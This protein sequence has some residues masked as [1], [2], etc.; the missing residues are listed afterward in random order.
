MGRRKPAGTVRLLLMAALLFCAAPFL[1]AAL[2]LGGVKV[3]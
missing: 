3:R 2:W 1:R